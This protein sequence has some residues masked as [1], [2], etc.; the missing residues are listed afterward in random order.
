[1]EVVVTKVKIEMFNLVWFRI[2]GEKPPEEEGSNDKY[3]RMRHRDDG[4]LSRRLLQFL[5][6][7]DIHS[8]IRASSGGPGFYYAGFFKPEAEKII[9]FLRGEGHEVSLGDAYEEWDES[10]EMK[11]TDHLLKGFPPDVGGAFAYDV[12]DHHTVKDDFP[13]KIDLRGVQPG[14]LIASFFGGFYQTVYDE[15]SELLDA[16]LEIEWVTDHEFQ[17]ELIREWV[18]NFSPQK[19]DLPSI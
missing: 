12:L 9:E 3:P 6:E 10:Y 8:P 5:I 13:A 17:L 16:A 2:Q 19:S 18:G 7:K 11:A 15:E 4:G 1:L 14:M